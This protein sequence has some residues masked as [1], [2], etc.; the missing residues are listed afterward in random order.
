[1][2]VLALIFVGVRYKNHSWKCNFIC[3]SFWDSLFI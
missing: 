3:S 1:M 2:F